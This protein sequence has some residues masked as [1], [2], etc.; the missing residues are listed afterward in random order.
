MRAVLR[1]SILTGLVT[2]LASCVVNPVTGERDLG[3]VSAAQEVQIGQE[4]YIPTQQMQGGQY[5]VDP[6]LADYVSRVGQRVAAKSPRNLPYEF[7]VLNNDVPNAWALPGGK[8]AVNRGLLVELDNEAEL[9]AVLGHEVVHAAARHSA[10]QMERGMLLQLGVVAVG[11]ASNDS[12]YAALAVG[13]GLLGAQ[14]ISTRYGREA[15]LES[16]KYGM[17]YLWEAGYDADAAV[18]LQETF[19]RLSEGRNSDWLSGLFASHPPS[20]ERVEKNRMTAAQLPDGGR[21]N[22]AEYQR[23]IASIKRDQPAYDAFNQALAALKDD[24][25]GDAET[26]ARQAVQ[27]QPREAK[28]H[29]LMATLKLKENAGQ[30]ARVYL[31]RS[32]ELNPALF[33]TRLQRGLL[34]LDGNELNA[35]RIDLE[36]ANT[37]LPT[38]SAYEGLG[39]IAVKQNRRDDAIEAYRVAATSDSEVGK[40][41][42]RK[43]AELEGT[44][45]AGQ[46]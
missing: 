37:L 21:L 23:A 16:D 6:A 38:A 36:A 22:R 20:S 27:I 40:R 28:F 12:D 33:E 1:I 24:R 43:L 42:A 4:N 44:A 8:I 17:Q 39:D 35:A 7:V 26:L 9:A 46:P 25:P 3:L 13:A 10:Q 11:V 30:Q 14:L 34:L 45:G 15:E 41:A 19:V 2:I 31:D 32:I 5:V 18:S 29:S